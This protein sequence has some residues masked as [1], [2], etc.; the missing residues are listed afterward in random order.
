VKIIDPA[1]IFASGFPLGVRNKILDAA[2]QELG[3]PEVLSVLIKGV[4]TRLR[5]GPGDMAMVKEAALSTVALRTGTPI[6][7]ATT[8]GIL[9]AW[10]V[11]LEVGEER[12]GATPIKLAV[13]I[14]SAANL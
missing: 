12:D 4:A 3:K 11:S 10:I 8:I 6:E 9:K 13:K 2:R 7:R 5:A 14:P 1:V